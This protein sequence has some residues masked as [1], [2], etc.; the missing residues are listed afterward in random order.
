MNHSS[1]SIGWPILLSWRWNSNASS[2]PHVGH[3]IRRV[4]PQAGVVPP[5]RRVADLRRELAQLVQGPPA[6]VGAHPFE[7]LDALAVGLQEVGDQDIHSLP[8]ARREVP[9]DVG[10]ADGFPHRPLDQR[11]TPLP[12]LTQLGGAAQGAAVE[13]EILL[14]ERLGQVPGSAV[15]HLPAQPVPPRRK[16]LLG[17]QRGQPGAETRLAEHDLVEGA[18]GRVQGRQPPAQ[19]RP[20]RQQAGPGEQ[21]VCLLAVAAR[22]VVPMVPGHRGLQ[23]EHPAGG[24]VGVR[25]ADQL[26]HALHMTNER[27]ADAS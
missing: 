18:S 2:G 10:P 23:R 17:E 3:E 20:L 19:V 5:S 12:A 4:D 22:D 21:V 14:D 6:G 8:G 25:E 26:E 13:V 9:A 16:V 11:D 27:V 1:R 24:L 15:D 7:L